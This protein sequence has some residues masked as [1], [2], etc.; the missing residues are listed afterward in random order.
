MSD[1]RVK[2][3]GND[4]QKAFDEAFSAGG[5]HVV[6]EEGGVFLGTVHLRKGVEVRLETGAELQGSFRPEA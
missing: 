3:N 6:P 5:D 2:K 1:S 4:I